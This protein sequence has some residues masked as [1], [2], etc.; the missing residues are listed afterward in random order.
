LIRDSD[1]LCCHSIGLMKK[2][3]LFK[4]GL[5]GPTHLN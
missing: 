1:Y 5:S 3:R 4:H 2:V